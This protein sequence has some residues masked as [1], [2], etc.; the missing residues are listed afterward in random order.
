MCQFDQG[1]RKSKQIYLN[2]LPQAMY[3]EILTRYGPKS[4]LL[5][6]TNWSNEKC[7]L[8]GEMFTPAYGMCLCDRCFEKYFGA[9]FEKKS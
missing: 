7:D 6:P 2:S 4:Y 9:Y 1:K 5:M 8:T 3:V